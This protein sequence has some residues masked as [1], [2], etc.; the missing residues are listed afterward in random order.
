[1]KKIKF[2][3][4]AFTAKPQKN[5]KSYYKKIKTAFEKFNAQVFV[6][7]SLAKSLKTK[8]Y[9][10]DYLCKKCDL[11]LSLGGDGTLISACRR[12]YGFDIPIIGVH[13]G[14]LGFLTE[15]KLDEFDGFLKQIYKND[16]FLENTPILE[17]EFKKGKEILKKV[18]F[19][20][21]VF[22][23]KTNSSMAK[24]NAFVNGNKFN[25]YFGDGVIVA[26]PSGST[27]YNLSANGPIVYPLTNVFLLTPICSHSLTQ[28]PLVLPEDFYIELQSDNKAMIIIDGQDT[29]SSKD[30]DSV[31]F[32]LQKN[33]VKL[34]R[35]NGRDYF[36]VLREKLRWGDE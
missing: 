32:R 25:S 27:A 20:D 3:K 14:R 24:I 26:T 11:L 15:A 2:E 23:R 31:G 1:M 7:A 35:H 6:E 36:S 21:A 10:L 30:Y 4:I 13:A 22:I 18:A 8:G 5:L 34:L 33:G 12:S 19:N 16:F 29:Y 17:V 9:E 28:R